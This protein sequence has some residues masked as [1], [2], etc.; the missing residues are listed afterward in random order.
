ME[1]N[2]K[3]ELKNEDRFSGYE[4]ITENNRKIELFKERVSKQI[5]IDAEKNNGTV[6]ITKSILQK[7]NDGLSGSGSKSGHLMLHF[8]RYTEHRTE[9]LPQ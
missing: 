9:V 5:S 7:A 8:C 1:K 6:Y 3:D 2:Q 4:D